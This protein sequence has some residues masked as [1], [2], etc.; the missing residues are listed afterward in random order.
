MVI[1]QDQAQQL[2]P[3]HAEKTVHLKFAKGILVKDI[4]ALGDHNLFNLLNYLLW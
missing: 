4:K 3:N 1:L 2:I